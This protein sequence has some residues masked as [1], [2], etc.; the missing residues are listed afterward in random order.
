MNETTSQAGSASPEGAARRRPRG[1]LWWT[2]GI[3]AG[4]ALSFWVWKDYLEDRIVPKRFG[5]VIPG[6]LFRSGQL[7]EALVEDVLRD[8]GIDVVGMV[9]GYVFQSFEETTS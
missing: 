4:I 1:R 9:S 6:Q 3:V 2:I 5:A 7:N 8:N